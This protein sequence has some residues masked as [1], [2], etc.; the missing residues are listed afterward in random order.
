MARLVEYL[1]ESRT[2]LGRFGKVSSGD[3]LEM[4]ERE[5]VTVQGNDNYKALPIP[6]LD[7][8]LPTVKDHTHYQLSRI[9][10]SEGRL[11]KWLARRGKSELEKVA[12]AMQ[13]VTGRDMRYG[14]LVSSM[15]IIDDIL[16]AANEFKWTR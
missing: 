8:E 1:G 5:Y 13:E 7:G 11:P 15:A 16:T 12:K 3:I 9:P 2:R 6:A 4:T 14:H 10:W